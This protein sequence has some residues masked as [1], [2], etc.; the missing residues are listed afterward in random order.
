MWREPPEPMT[1][2][3]F[4]TSGVAPALPKLSAEVRSPP[5]EPLAKLS[6]RSQAGFE[7]PSADQVKNLLEFLTNNGVN[8]RLIGHPAGPSAVLA[9]SVTNWHVQCQRKL[10]TTV[11]NRESRW[12]VCSLNCPYPRTRHN[13]F[14]LPRSIEPSRSAH[15]LERDRHRYC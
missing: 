8:E 10:A 11:A 14:H 12:A 4:S 9:A 3:A 1:G 15:R 5:T 13:H 2:F 7:F 6:G